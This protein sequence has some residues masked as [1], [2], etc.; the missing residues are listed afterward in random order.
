M[1]LR[2]LFQGLEVPFT[3]DVGSVD[4]RGVTDDSREVRPGYLFV[5]VKGFVT[6]GHIFASQAVERGAVALVVEDELTLPVPQVK[7]S[8]TRR[9]LPYLA[10][11]FFSRPSDSLTFVGVT[12]TNGKTTVTHLLAHVLEK[13]GKKVLLLGT[14]DYRLGEKRIKAERTTPPPL[15][16][17]RFLRKA[18][19]EGISY[20]VMEVSSHA[21]SLGRVEGLQFQVSTFTNLSRDHLDFHRT[22]DHYYWA[23]SHLFTHYTSG[24]SVVNL[25]DPYG[26]RLKVDLG[27]NVLGFSLG[28]NAPLKGEIKRADLN[29]LVLGVEEDR[30]TFTLNSHLVGTYNAWNLLAA[31]G[32]LAPLGVDPSDVLSSLAT[33]HGVKG[34]LEPVANA[35]GVGVFVDYAHTPD[36]LRVVLETLGSMTQG[37]LILVFGCG[38]DRD[39]G[40]R[41]IMGAVACQWAN[42]LV[43]TSDNPRTEDPMAIIQDILRGT[44]REVVVEP[45]R[46]EA[47]GLALRMAQP[48][49]VVLIAGKGHEDYQIVGE[50]IFPFDDVEITREIM[51]ELGWI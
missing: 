30:G 39:R 35:N 14:V 7:V 13:M 12:G 36:A 6:D 15:L 11:N 40:K 3:S 46:R 29:G 26:R 27:G 28:G 37:C 17:W 32:A 34:R 38:G 9:I 19:D 33:F 41:P 23:K 50:E 21:L 8:D 51:E 2:E 16:L 49:D 48:G 47:I 25:D 31:W 43:V 45:D 18:V 5:C 1:K 10:R 20:V 4:V 22:M 44:T 24:V 42:K